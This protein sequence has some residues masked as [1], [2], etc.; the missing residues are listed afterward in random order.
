MA[1]HEE[2]WHK[3][4]ALIEALPVEWKSINPGKKMTGLR[5]MDL[6]PEGS[7]SVIRARGG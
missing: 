7:M 6:E 5:F 4:G 2:L 3:T 1:T